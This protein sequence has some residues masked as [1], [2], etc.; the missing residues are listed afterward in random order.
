MAGAQRTIVKRVIVGTP[1]K[2]V[3]ASG[4]DL[5]IVGDSGTGTVSV[6]TAQTLT[7][8]GVAPLIAKVGVVDERTVTFTIDPATGQRVG[9]AKF[10][11]DHFNVDVTGNVRLNILDSSDQVT[12]SLIPDT[13]SAYDLGSS[14]KKWRKLFVSGS[15]IQLGN[16]NLRESNGEFSATVA[17]TGVPVAVNLDGNTTDNLTEGSS[18][19]T[20]QEHV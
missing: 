1:I 12:H 19:Y 16:L 17:A 18:N 15:T 7:F 8:D 14:S 5:N 4:S 2:S 9:V 6:G 11:S 3:R 20:T 10:D 13:D